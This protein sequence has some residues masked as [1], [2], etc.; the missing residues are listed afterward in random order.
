M[1]SLHEAFP[2]KLVQMGDLSKLPGNS[3]KK[4]ISDANEQEKAVQEAYDL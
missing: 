2:L 3:F 4:Y 1:E